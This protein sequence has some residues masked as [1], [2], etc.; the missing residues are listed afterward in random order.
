LGYALTY[1]STF[2]S[3]HIEPTQITILADNDYY[4][5]PDTGKTPPSSSQRFANFGVPLLQAHK[6]GLGSS[7][8]LVTSFVAAVLT[9]YLSTEHFDLSTA[10][11]RARLHNLAQAAHCA[12][13]GKVGSGFDVAAAVYGSCVYRRF[14]PAILTRLGEASSSGFSARLKAVVEENGGPETK[15]DTQVTKDTV[16]IPKGLRLIMC[17]VDCGSQTVGMVKKVLAWR[18]ENAEEAK[19]LWDVL[20]AANDMLRVGLV[21]LSEIQKTSEM[22][23]KNTLDAFASGE[24]VEGKTLA[25]ISKVTS[26][27]WNIRSLIRQMSQK[28]GVPIEPASQTTLLDQCC[29]QKGVIGGVVPGAGGYDA[30]ALLVVDDEAVLSN[31]N[32]FLAGFSID[33]SEEEGKIGRVRLLGVREEMEGVRL[34]KEDVAFPFVQTKS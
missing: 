8:A 25:S 9:N 2:G 5:Q 18:K 15:W 3:S 22:E 21:E 33:A 26:T 17:D 14:S 31:L 27:I 28:A 7:A 34:E 12:A 29:G 23:Y 19:D 16:A 30:V 10:Q 1:I 20:Q 4:S 32:H 13:Q 11:D 24:K 6:T